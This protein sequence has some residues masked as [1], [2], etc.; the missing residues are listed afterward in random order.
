[1]HDILVQLRGVSI[2]FRVMS[3]INPPRSQRGSIDDPKIH[4]LSFF[5]IFSQSFAGTE[6]AQGE[7]GRSK[8]PRI[9]FSFNL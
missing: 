9:E 5:N 8:L 3:L 2:L 4:F 7:Q 6:L 1:M